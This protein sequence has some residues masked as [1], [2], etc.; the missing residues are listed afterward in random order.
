MINTNGIITN[1][2]GLKDKMTDCSLVKGGIFM[3]ILSSIRKD[4][5]NE[6]TFLELKDT[7]QGIISWKTRGQLGL[8][9]P[10]DP[11]TS[12]TIAMTGFQRRL[13]TNKEVYNLILE[14]FQN[15]GYDIYF[16]ERSIRKV[17][18]I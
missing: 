9:N 7:S 2:P 10:S 6:D 12:A 8:K 3:D 15:K 11:N 14:R 4:L 18:T 16:Y 5:A 1:C 13:Y 17:P